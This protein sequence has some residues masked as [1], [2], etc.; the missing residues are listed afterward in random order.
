MEAWL[1]SL[2]PSRVCST[3]GPGLVEQPVASPD[4]PDP[5]VVRR[6]SQDQPD[7][8]HAQHDAAV[9]VG[10]RAFI[11]G[12]GAATVQPSGQRDLDDLHAPQPQAEQDGAE[13]RATQAGEPEEGWD[14]QAVQEELQPRR[15][16]P[17]VGLLHSGVP[18]T[19]ANEPEE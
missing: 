19:L 9:E 4:D 16:F 3:D 10:I 15:E 8:P 7:P 2:L 12:P 18:Q 14:H 1:K 11:L 5:G 6:D 13:E 17:V